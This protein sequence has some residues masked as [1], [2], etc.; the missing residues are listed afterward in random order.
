MKVTLLAAALSLTASMASAQTTITVQYPYPE[1]F[2]GTQKEM[3]EAFTKAHPD[4][5]VE[6]R[7]A[8]KEY[9]DA[10]QRILREGI[11]GNTP[12]VTFQG[13]NRVRI[14]ADKGI[15]VALDDF[16]ANEKD[17]DAAGYH[18]GMRAAGTSNGKVYGLPFAISLPIVYYNMDLVKKAGLDEKTLPKTWEEITALGKKIHSQGEAA[19]VEVEWAITGNWL[20]QSLNFANGG[21][22]LTADETKVA[23]TDDAGK[24]AIETLARLVTEAKSPN[25]SSNDMFAAFVAGKVGVLVTSTA[26]VNAFT[27]QIG[28]KFEFKTGTY[29]DL[30]P[31]VSRLPAGGNVAIITAK[32][33]EKQ[34]AAWEFVKFATGPEG[35]AIMVKTTG[36]MA[37]NNKAVEGLKEFYAKNPN[38]AVALSQLSYLTGWYA[39]PGDNGLKITDVIKDRLQS[40]MDGSRANEPQAVL[41]DMAADVQ[42]L[43]PRK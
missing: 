42:A 11:T 19:G 12:D 13:L 22:M 2:D 40:I 23:F 16:I 43:L 8:Y 38:Q 33:K 34:K 21:S 3:A 18:E 32:D 36:Y 10:T 15:A 39:F 24:K 9:E 30:K 31:G 6:F 14:L 26:R 4:I 17:F 35:G 20:W 7:P 29:P 37:P 1:V 25:M 5:K 28:N 41:T 27:R